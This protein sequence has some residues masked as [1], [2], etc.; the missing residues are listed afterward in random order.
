MQIILVIKNELKKSLRNKKKFIIT[1][2]L[3]MIAVVVALGVNNIMKPSI[4]IGVINKSETELAKEFIRSAND[5]EGIV[6]T[7]GDL[8]TVNTD[9]IMGKYTTIIEFTEN[10]KYN[11][12]ALDS[13]IKKSFDKIISDFKSTGSLIGLNSIINR[14]NEQQIPLVNRSIS[15]ILIALLIN[16]TVV[17]C[18]IIKDRKEGVLKRYIISPNTSSYYILGVLIFNFVI[19]SIQILVS[20]IFIRV[21]GIDLGISLMS[22]IILGIIVALISTVFATLITNLCSSEIQANLIASAL[23]VITALIGGGFLPIEKMPGGIK[24][25]SNFTITKWVMEISSSINIGGFQKELLFPLISITVILVLSVIAS[26]RVGKK[27]FI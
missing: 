9:M 26:I 27:R 11:V 2:I 25:L 10:E 7:K 16:C 23:A 6:A 5:I 18:S 22:F 17:A 14:I 8:S 4:N 24:F 15:F 12:Y 13:N 21:I 19:T 3:P 1:M 20:I